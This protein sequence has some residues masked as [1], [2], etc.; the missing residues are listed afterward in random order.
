MAITDFL[1][2][3]AR[4]LGQEVALVELNPTNER[5]QG[6][7]WRE[8]SLIESAADA[9]YRR[10]ITWRDFDRRA[11]RFANLLLSRGLTRGTKVAILLMNC[12]EWLPIYFGILKAGCIAVPMNFRYSGD[13]I[14]YCVDLA[15]VSVLVFGPE[16]TTRIDPIVGEMTGVKNFFFVGKDTPCYAENCLNLSAYCS[17][18][19]PPVKLEDSDDAAIYF[20]SGTTGFPKAIL[21]NHL[22]LVSSCRTAKAN[23][24]NK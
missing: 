10:E 8:F 14:R 3:N 13:E 21:H 24:D 16:F 4:L 6:R 17:S 19:A 1:E 22:S 20:S 5:D 11:N 18:S 12:L 23:I 15:D 9:P 7:T 2:Q